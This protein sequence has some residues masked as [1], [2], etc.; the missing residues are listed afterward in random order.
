MEWGDW[1]QLAR[2]PLI[3]LLY[4]PRV[5][6]ELGAF[7]GMRTGRGNRSTRRK[8]TPVP[9]CCTTNPTWFDLV[10]NRRLTAW[11]TARPNYLNLRYKRFQTHYWR[12][13]EPQTASLNK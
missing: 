4:Q 1:V 8:P 6:D 7:G 5:I 2:R 9:L 10:G 11:G 13:L 12:I 3:A